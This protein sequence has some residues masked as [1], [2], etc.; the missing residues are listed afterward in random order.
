[1]CVEAY[2]E[3]PSNGCPD[4]AVPNFKQQFPP[5]QPPV[6]VPYQQRWMSRYLVAYPFLL[7]IKGGPVRESGERGAA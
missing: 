6:L 5:T 7:G 4:A 2:L 1:M 3:L